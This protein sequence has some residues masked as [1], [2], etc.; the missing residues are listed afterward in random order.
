MYPF[1]LYIYMFSIF[2]MV[3]LKGEKATIELSMNLN[4][5]GLRTPNVATL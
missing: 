4:N 1:R 2:H 5:F 3:L